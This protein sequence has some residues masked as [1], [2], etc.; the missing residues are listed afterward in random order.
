M[1]SLLVSE[2][3]LEHLA[4]LLKVMEL[5]LKLG[6]LVIEFESGFILLEKLLFCFLILYF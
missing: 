2:V 3:I 4:V 1:L 6:K 5:C